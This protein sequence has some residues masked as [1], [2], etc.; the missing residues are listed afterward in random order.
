MTMITPSYL[1]ETIEYSSLH[2][3][4]STLEDPTERFPKSG[5][6]YHLF[7]RRLYRLIGKENLRNRRAHE[8]DFIKHRTSMDE[9]S[10]NIVLN[11]L[12]VLDRMA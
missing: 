10:D 2:A 6:I 5:T 4:R 7:S 3:C 9:Q 11:V 12:L 1:G 8:L